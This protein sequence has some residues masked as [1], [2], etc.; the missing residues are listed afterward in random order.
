MPFDW[1]TPFGYFLALSFQCV[2]VYFGALIFVPLMSSLIGSALLLRA[3]V[4][5]ISNDLSFL[6]VDFQQQQQINDDCC[7]EIIE[8]FINVIQ[9]LSLVKQL[10]GKALK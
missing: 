7:R 3:F 6:N 8:Q 5:D 9:E 4:V 2:A 1:Q 10:S